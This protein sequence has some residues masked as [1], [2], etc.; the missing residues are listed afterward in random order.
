MIPTPPAD[1]APADP[2]PAPVAGAE[3]FAARLH[4]F[5]ERNRATVLGAGVAI[6]LGIVGWEGWNYYRAWRDEGIR[7][8]YARV[9]SQPE[10]LAGF[11]AAHAGHPLAG[12]ARLSLADDLYL[13]GSYN[14]AA[15]HYTQAAA[16]LELGALRDRARLGAAMSRVSA[17]DATVGEA[18]LRA[19]SAEAAVLANVRAEAAFHLA[20]LAHDAG[21]D[22]D[23]K[24][25]AAE[26]AQL[27][28]TG[29]WAQRAF[30]LSSRLETGAPSAPAGDAPLSVQFKPGGE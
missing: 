10:K 19:L 30:Q 6:L 18:A 14:A 16:A 12:V 22:D 27:D 1:H 28:P 3:E 23:A 29:L 11:A 20:T 24:K 25:S 26:A 2:T 21:R 13:K 15:E 17:G 8:D 7:A 5:W 4:D 9:A